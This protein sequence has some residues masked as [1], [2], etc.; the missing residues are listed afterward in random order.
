MVH[1]FHQHKQHNILGY[2]LLNEPFPGSRWSDCVGLSANKKGQLSFAIKNPQSCVNFDKTTMTTFTRRAINAIRKAA[3]NALAFYE[4]EVFYDL[5]VPSHIGPLHLANTVF[6]FHNYNKVD[7][8]LPFKNVASQIQL[9]D[10]AAFMSE[11]G[12]STLSKVEL[13]RMLDL[14]NQ[15]NVSPTYWAY[16]NN[17]PYF[18]W[19]PKQTDSGAVFGTMPNN[20][21]KQALVFDM[22]KPLEADN[23]K[24]NKINSLSRMYA[25]FVAGRQVSIKVSTDNKKIKIKYIPL[26]H[27]TTQVFIPPSMNIKT[28]AVTMADVVKKTVTVQGRLVMVSVD[29]VKPQ[30]TAILVIKAS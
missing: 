4:P 27:Q 6:N 13:N 5:G 17:P 12:A 19:V 15:F 21:R 26:L 28:I 2:D 3:P 22:R 8:R 24:W 1:Y 14:A 16:V 7:M 30:Q 18:F 9:N 25:P 11:F 29:Q 20:P 10:S 23:V